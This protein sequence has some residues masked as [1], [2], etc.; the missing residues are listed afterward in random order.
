M[1]G[2][3]DE[4]L[5][6]YRRALQLEP[7]DPMAHSGLASI[8]AA[9]GQLDEALLHYERAIALDPKLVVAHNNL[10]QLLVGRGQFGQALAHYRE[11]RWRSNPLLRRL[12]V[13]RAMSWLGKEGFTR[14]WH[15]RKAVE[16]SHQTPAMQC[17]LAWLLAVCPDASVRNSEEALALATQANR[18]TG[19]QEPHVLDTLAAAYAAAGWFPEAVAT[20]RKAT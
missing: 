1:Q 18:L 12:I 15:Y 7:D 13:T 20:V 19:G 14:R 9:R 3:L 11:L 16:V 2:R 10:A 6:H 4:A 5:A 8:L 17:A